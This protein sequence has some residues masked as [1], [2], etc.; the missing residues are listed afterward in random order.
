MSPQ[1]HGR[2]TSAIAV[3]DIS[4]HGIWVLAQG[5]ELF[6]PYDSFP[7]FKKG[8][9]EAVLNVEEQGPGHSTTGRSW[10]SISE[11]TRCATRSATRS[12]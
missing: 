9:V 11:S 1:Q 8:S 3:T 6:L 10:T 7:W 4:P 2:D 5:E 12:R